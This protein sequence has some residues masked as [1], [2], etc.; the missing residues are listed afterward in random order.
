MKCHAETKQ[1]D[2][3][4]ARG[5]RCKPLAG[6][7]PAT[8]K[9]PGTTGTGA[10]VTEHLRCRNAPAIRVVPRVTTSPL[11]RGRGFL[12]G[13]R[14]GMERAVRKRLRL[15]QYDYRQAGA[16]FVTICVDQ[17]RCILWQNPVGAHR[18]RP[19]DLQAG[20]CLSAAGIAV[21]LAIRQIPEHYQ[22]VRVEKYVIMPNHVHLLLSFQHIVDIQDGGRTLCAPTLSR[23]IKH[24][25]ECVTKQLGRPIWQKSYHDHIIRDERDFLQVWQYIDGNPAQWLEDSYYENEGNGG[26]SS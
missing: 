6:T 7:L 15:S 25:K 19:E 10:P 18:V 5:R 9:Q 1:K 22:A 11:T 26:S 4:R 14:N 23:V 17:R 21:D 3:P 2:A 20:R 8:S 24:L 12:S 16:Y 13:G